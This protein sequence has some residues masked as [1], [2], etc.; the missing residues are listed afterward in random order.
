MDELIVPPAMWEV[1]HDGLTNY[2]MT[3]VG[4]LI[5][6]PVELS[7]R[8]K[9]SG[10]FRAELG[11]SR[12]L[13][14]DPPR[15][16]AVIRD[17]VERKQAELSL[18]QSEE[19]LRL[20]IENVKDYAIYMLDP[21]G[22][23]ATWNAGAEHIEGYRA[24]EIIGKHYS[25]FFIPEDV[26]HG[27]PREYLKQAEREGKVLSEGWR[28]ARIARLYFWSQGTVTALHDETGKL[29]G[30]S[31]IAHDMTQQKEAED[32]IRQL[33]EELEHRVRERTA[34]LKGPNQEL[35]AFSYSVSHDLRAPLRHISGY[36][37]ILRSEAAGRLDDEANEHLRTIADSAKD[38]G[39]L[40]DALLAF[41]RMGR[42]D[43]RAASG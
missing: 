19:R 43:M 37:E 21:D 41:S 29:R 7:L 13:G 23:V 33:F 31:K 30:F 36:V 39:E 8:R 22:N 28:C 10:E 26:E 9:D 15:C 17:I 12:T 42:A 11:I 3:G 18:R 38:L 25:A 24:E 14:E 32:K 6:R 27:V 5:G 1:Y 16:T 4:S 20:L 34:Q 2:L 35:E 40:I